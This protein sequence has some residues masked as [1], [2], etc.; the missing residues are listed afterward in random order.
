M[1]TGKMRNA[2]AELTP[3][4]G[5]VRLGLGPALVISTWV[6]PTLVP[7]NSLFAT[8]APHTLP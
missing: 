5:F 4:G 6:T 1:A 2:S 3:G 8:P 7:R